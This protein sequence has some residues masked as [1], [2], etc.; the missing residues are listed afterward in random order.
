MSTRPDSIG[1]YLEIEPGAGSAQRL[2]AALGVAP[3]HA[4][5][6][7]PRAGAQID[8]TIARGL[9]ERIQ[10]SGAAALIERDAD[11]AKELRADGVHLPWSA[12]VAG[13]YVGARDILG[14]RF[15]VGAM[16]GGS[17]HDAMTLAEAGADYIGFGLPP[18]IA[19][20]EA[21][22]AERRALV[23]WWAQIFEVPCVAFGVLTSAA[24]GECAKAGADFLGVPLPAGDTQAAIAD[25]IHTVLHAANTDATA[26]SRG[27]K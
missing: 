26:L 2:E 6:I 16:A 25:R 24:A 8:R 17:R 10:A 1:L 22:V 14:N 5:L 3:V 11:L 12:D 9:I 19:D 18:E 23:E 27:A 21:A 7:K 15:I 13:A 4:V 20:P